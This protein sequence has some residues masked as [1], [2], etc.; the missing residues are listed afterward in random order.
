MENLLEKKVEIGMK[1]KM[2]GKK[3]KNDIYTVEDIYTTYNSKK[4][5]V[6]VT[7]VASHIF[8]GQ[9]VFNYDVP[10]ATIIRGIKEE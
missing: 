2:G 3:R 4:E 5:V 7:Y 10:A 6:R 1:F 9:K 8:L